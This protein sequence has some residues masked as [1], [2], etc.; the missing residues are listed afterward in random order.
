VRT[1]TLPLFLPL[2][3]RDQSN[4]VTL[5]AIVQSNQIKCQPGALRV[6]VSLSLSRSLSCPHRSESWPDRFGWLFACTCDLA[7]ISQSN[8]TPGICPSCLCLS[9]CSRLNFRVVPKPVQVACARPSPSP[10]A[11]YCLLS[12]CFFV[13]RSVSSPVS[14]LSWFLSFLFLSS[15]PFCLFCLFC[16]VFVFDSFVSVRF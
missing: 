13:V 1:P 7:T 2:S 9:H 12:S 11:A 15:F 5:I 10:P 16:F 4:C 3:V 14:S 6:R 8:Q